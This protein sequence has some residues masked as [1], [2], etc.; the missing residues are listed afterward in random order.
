MGNGI[1]G[2]TLERIVRE[3][4]LAL[5]W[6]GVAGGGFLK[7]VVAEKIVADFFCTLTS[8]LDGMSSMM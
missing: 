6:I 7:V 8:P 2:R 3:N 4:I 1:W 5:Y